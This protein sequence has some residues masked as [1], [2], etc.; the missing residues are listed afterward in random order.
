MAKVVNK[1][2]PATI[3]NIVEE[4]TRRMGNLLSQDEVDALLAPTR[5]ELRTDSPEEAEIRKHKLQLMLSQGF[6]LDDLHGDFVTRFRRVHRGYDRGE[7]G[8][9]EFVEQANFLVQEYLQDRIAGT[10]I[11]MRRDSY[12]VKFADLSFRYEGVELREHSYFALR[13]QLKERD[14][15]T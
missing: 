5:E 4:T 8:D 10:E 15:S 14:C 12:L 11:G 13:E 2:S 6:A 7:L 9:F 1:P 3:R